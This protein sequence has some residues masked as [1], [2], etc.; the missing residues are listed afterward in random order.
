VSSSDYTPPPTDYV[1]GW[2]ER[3]RRGSAGA[4]GQLLAYHR[5]YLLALAND[6]LPP[7]LQAKLGASDVVQDTFLE[8][9]RDFGQF[10]G[11]SR[12]E[13]LAW[14][15]QILL[16]NLANVG[17][18]FRETGKRQIQREIV[19]GGDPTKELLE[20]VA[21]DGST[22]SAHAVRQEQDDALKQALAQLPKSE[23]DVIEW[24]TYERCTFEEI[25]R[26]LERSAGA[27]RKL[28]ARAVERL[29]KILVAGDESR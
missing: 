15:R 6:H 20:G 11:G 14:L 23:R 28:W 21:D 17:R 29:Q 18:Q 12:E 10:Q 5:Q 1:D 2:I 3:A 13:L 22:P 19:L 26:R 8:A 25:G 7:D 16:H 24:R 4:L 27:A 9:Q